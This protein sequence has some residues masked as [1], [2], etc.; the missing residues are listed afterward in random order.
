MNYQQAIADAIKQIRCR[1]AAAAAVTTAETT[2]FGFLSFFSAVADAATVVDCSTTA[3]VAA[4]AR[5]TTTDAA[6]GSGFSFFWAAAV[7]ASAATT[8]ADAANVLI[9]EGSHM[10]ALAPCNNVYP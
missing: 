3:D 10:R 8:A 5:A 6:T 2:G 9:P 4:A 7:T 1:S